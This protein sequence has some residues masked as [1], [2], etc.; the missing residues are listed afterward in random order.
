MSYVEW[1]RFSSH[2]NVSHWTFETLFE[3]S[4]RRKAVQLAQGHDIDRLEG[5][6]VIITG[7][8]AASGARPRCS[9]QEG[10]KLI[11]VDRTGGVKETV[12]LVREAGG[13][14]E[15]VMAD[16]GSEKDVIAFIG[17]AIATHGKLDAIG[18]MPESAAGWC[19]L[20]NK[21]WSIGRKSC[22][23]T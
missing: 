21:P 14:A 4:A 17:K 2:F 22:A 5:E 3:N 9:S 12:D 10:A 7:A 20:P 16:A 19:R 15:A 11:A 8:G 23:S 1:P 18:P 13:V 6:S